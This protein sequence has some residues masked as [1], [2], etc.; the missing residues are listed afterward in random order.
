MKFTI[1]SPYDK[2]IY[3]ISWIELNTPVGNFVIQP[4]HA[5]TILTLS[6][7]EKITFGLANGK[8]ESLAI[9]QGIAHIT[10]DSATVI[11]SE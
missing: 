9:K 4:G 5:P 1:V 7:G 8:R 2:K 10:R 11:L 3:A 6:A